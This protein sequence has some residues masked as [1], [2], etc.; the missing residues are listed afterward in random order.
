MTGLGSGRPTGDVWPA[1]DPV[2]VVHAAVAGRVRVHIEGLYRNEGLRLALQAGLGNRPGIRSASANSL[3][4]N[5]LILFDPARDLREVL[6]ELGLVIAAAGVVHTRQRTAATAEASDAAPVWA[7]ADP[8]VDG[9]RGVVSEVSRLVG[10]LLATGPGESPEALTA[11][12]VSE[13]GAPTQPWHALEADQV[14]AFWQSSRTNGLTADAAAERLR[15]YGRNVLPEPPPPSWVK[16]FVRQFESLPVLLL[17]GAS[18]L[19]VFTGGLVDALVIVGVVA[20]NAVIGT[21]TEHHA[22]L[23]LATLTRFGQPS[24][25]V[26]RD[27]T[28]QEVAGEDVVVG[29]LVALTRGSYVP[30]DARLIDV[31]HLTV[32]ESILT[33]ESVPS[34]KL[35]TPVAAGPSLPLGDR[36][37]MV[38]RGTV[39]TGGSGVAIVVATGLLTEI[40][41]I[42]VLI[43][44]SAQPVTP[45]QRQLEQLGTQLAVGASLVCGGVFGVGLLRGLPVLQMLQAAVALAVAAIPE[46]LP[47]VATT[48]LAFGVRDLR[49]HNVLVRRLAAVETLGA[50]QAMCLDKTGTITMN[51]MTAVEVVAGTRRY[52]LAAQQTYLNGRRV[53]PFA[54]ADFIQLLETASLCNE[55]DV[56]LENNGAPPTLKGTPTETAI[57]QAAMDAGIDVVALRDRYRTLST[58]QRSDARNYM[59]TTHAKPDGE[60][61]AIKGSPLEVIPLCTH[62]LRGSRIV[63]MTP[64]ERAAIGAENE[65]M[66]GRALRVL[67][68]ARSDGNGSPAGEPAVV[69]LGLIGITDPPRAGLKDLVAAFRHAG[70]RT[71]MITGDQSQTAYAIGREL[72]LAGG[73]P[74]VMIDST[75]LD[76]V[77]P[78]LLRG[79]VQ[80]VHVFSRVNPSHK[81]Q[82]VR[83]LQSAGLVVAMTGDGIN[84][85]PALKAADIGIAMGQGA[86]V[87]REVAGVVLLD[88]NIETMLPCIVE[89][90]T[91]Y[92]DIRKAVHFITATNMSEILVMLGGVTFAGGQ[93]LNPRQLLWINLLT[94]VFPE[95]ALAVEPPEEGVLSRAPRDPAAPIVSRQDYV[96]LGLQSSVM[97]A[98]TL[99]S[100]A[101]G[102]ARYGPGAQSS[103]MAFLTLTAVQ[104]LHTLSARSET[105]TIFDRDMLP[106]NGY[107]PL[108]I[109]TGFGVELVS[110]F[111][112]WLRTLLGTAPVGPADVAIC[113]GLAVS[114]LC[115]NELAKIAWRSAR[116]AL[117]PAATAEPPI[118]QQQDAYE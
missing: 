60:L 86:E 73:A 109:A 39:V 47:T 66:A 83:A 41:R 37:N 36:V 55:A 108:A 21:V 111:V 53:K 107:V 44:S 29:D 12:A 76:A 33:G 117:P 59:R 54:H 63:P 34:T 100:Y 81:L 80:R 38:Y 19:S 87:A 28:I 16:V 49:Q 20:A 51:R 82:I 64:E 101:A 24:A 102:V 90:R 45:L 79:L 18:V 116:P 14:V 25:L 26:I 65:R 96:R 97:T 17:L 62:R 58:Q 113:G 52:R 72:D 50:M 89:G 104:L 32:D 85:G 110:S 67:G 99:A 11:A 74:L 78:Q 40:G 35:T 61:I 8:I 9:V 57:L 77:A 75:H 91:V 69:W 94:D 43:E 7:V 93:L 84:D 13:P 30:A 114:S 5:V 103:T 71:I 27:A 31:A 56:V 23:T 68:V 92:D 3:T 4:G 22:E 118:Q 98:A 95:L 48:T 10:L 106:A 88:D 2:V 42:R 15:T 6:S 70:I 1:G 115:A 46:G 105:H 112:P